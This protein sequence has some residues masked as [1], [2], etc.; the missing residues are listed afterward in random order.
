MTI[1][2]MKGCLL[3]IFIPNPKLM[4]PGTKIILREETRPLEL[5]EL[6]IYFGKWII[7][8]HN[9]LFEIPIINTHPKGSS[10]LFHKY[11]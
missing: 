10:I 3:D 11:H 9:D 7:V 2:G 8:L 6:V 1:T 5:I 4:I